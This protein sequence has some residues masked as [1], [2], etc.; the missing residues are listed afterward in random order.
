MPSGDYAGAFA[1]T[2]DLSEKI[3]QSEAED[4]S[5]RAL[6]LQSIAHRLA[7]ASSEYLHSIVRRELWGYAKDEKLSP[8]QMFQARYAGIRPA[9][10]Y[11]S[12]PDQKLTFVLSG[13]LNFDEIGITLT[14]NGAME[15]SATV[16]GLYI[17]HPD[18]SYFMLGP[19]AD[20][21]MADYARRRGMSI[22]DVRR[23]LAHN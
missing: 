20:D 3:S 17:A 5:Y 18:A 19:I 16:C 14:E 4:D 2:V 23:L 15:P 10:G 21:Q 7:E 12:L 13:L 8:L 1:V 22:D 6:L 9:V 11:P